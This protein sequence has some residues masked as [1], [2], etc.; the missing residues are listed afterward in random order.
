MIELKLTRIGNSL[1]VVLPKEAVGRLNV[2]KGD[3]LWLTD[4]PD[5]YRLTGH[6]PEFEQQMHAA[7]EVM[8]KRRA[9]L[10]ELAK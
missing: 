3:R 9:A 6:D 2:E 7:R 8:K 1:G 5:G 10:R 4:A